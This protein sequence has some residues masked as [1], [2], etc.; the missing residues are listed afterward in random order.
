MLNSSILSIDRTLSGATTLHQSWLGSDGNEGTHHSQKFQHFWSLP[1]RLFSVISWTLVWGV[2]SL[3]RNAVSV[4][5]QHQLTGPRCLEYDVKRYLVM[6]FQFKSSGEC[7]I[8]LQC[9]EWRGISWTR[10]HV[11]N[12]GR[13]FFNLIFLV[14]FW[15]HQCVFPF[16]DLWV[17]LNFLSYCLSIAFFCFVFLVAIF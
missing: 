4:F 1:I 14:L 13:A 17:L 10:I 8:S 9:H 2:L 7:V 3:C 12:N 11:F 16:S 5:L 6:R 15:I